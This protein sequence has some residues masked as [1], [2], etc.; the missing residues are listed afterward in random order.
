MNELNY[1]LR[2]IDRYH[3][4]TDCINSPLNIIFTS[5]ISNK[6][7]QRQQNN[8]LLSYLVLLICFMTFKL[9]IRSK[10]FKRKF[11]FIFILI[12]ENGSGNDGNHHYE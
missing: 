9:R 3:K 7:R 5:V 6:S 12:G 4:Y 8:K 2:M 11:Y 10:Y 1:Q